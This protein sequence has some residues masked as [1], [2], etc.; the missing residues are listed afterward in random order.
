MNDT[1][2][3]KIYIL[4]T[5]FPDIWSKLIGLMTLSP[6]T[7]ASIG[8]EEDLNTY[9][10]FVWKGFIVE[11]ITRYL[12]RFRKPFPCELYEFDVSVQQYEI[13]KRVVHEFAAHKHNYTFARWELVFGLFH[14][15]IIRRNRYYCSQFIADVLKES[16]VLQSTRNSARYF[17]KDF[18][19]L[20]GANMVY[21]G[22]LLGYVYRYNLLPAHVEG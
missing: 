19:K 4:L 12:K 5:R 6:Y 3:K 14:M 9:Y 20:A 17:P 1:E 13:V 18:G 10:S 16:E 21:K 22:N 8:L 2:K 7:H 15:P 11:D